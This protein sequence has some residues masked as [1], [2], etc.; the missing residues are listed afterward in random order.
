MST[1][2]NS[3]TI[4]NDLNEEIK[5]SKNNNN[6]NKDNNNKTIGEEAKETLNKRKEF[7]AN[8]YTKQKRTLEIITLTFNFLFLFGA[9]FQ[10]YQVFNYKN[11]W[12]ILL[13]SAIFGL[14]VAD[15][16]SG[17][18]HWTFD[19]WGS[20]T[21]PFVGTFIRSFR[22]HHLDPKAMTKHD[23]IEANADSCFLAVPQLAYLTFVPISQESITTQLF[24]YIFMIV[25]LSIT[26]FTNQIHKWAHMT[27]PP[28][29][30]QLLQDC[31]LILDRKTH[32]KHHHP[33]Y[34]RDYCITNGWMNPIL[35]S[36]NYWRNVEW[37]ITKLT[38]AIPRAD[39]VQWTDKIY[40]IGNK[41]EIK[42][43]N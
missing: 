12:W 17:M 27:H 34:D 28:K 4:L 1:I 15:F 33:P 32:N 40:L 8:G 30:V 6:N 36:I 38:G 35:A 9:I 5:N 22:E 13:F 43:N 31:R 3:E 2:V 25:T 14:F 11:H 7:L 18:L 26:G 39:D 29:W 16:I 20:I 19:T 23:W 24:I 10:V 41:T 37:I 42:E 21:T